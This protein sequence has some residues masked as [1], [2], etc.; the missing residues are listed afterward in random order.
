MT[1]KIAVPLTIDNQIDSHFG[2]CESFGVFTIS[3]KNEIIE[4]KRV[5]SPE[6]CGCKSDIARILA[7]DGVKIMLAGGIG[8]GA[9]NVLNNNGIEVIRGCGGNAADVVN[10]FLMGFVADSGAN[11]HQHSSQPQGTQC[12]HH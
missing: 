2:H 9:I 12:P 6:G 3:D 7:A 11:C 4:S 5:S 8:E 1:T 10:L